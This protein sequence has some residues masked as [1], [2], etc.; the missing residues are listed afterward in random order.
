[1]RAQ[2]RMASTLLKTISSGIRAGPISNE[3]LPDCSQLPGR[4]RIGA[5]DDMEKEVGLG[6]LG[7]GRAERLDEMVGEPPHES[8][9]VGDDATRC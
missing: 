2:L 1:M 7:Q 4:V 8:D 6:H 3:H 5:V 9:G